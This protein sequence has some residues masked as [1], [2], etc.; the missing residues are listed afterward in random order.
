MMLADPASRFSSEL[1]VTRER[2]L[3][4]TAGF[5]GDRLLGPKLA[6]VNPPLW[7]IGHVGWFQERW[8]LRW[9]PDGGLDDSL[10]QNADALY[11]SSAVAHD[12]R[13]NLPLPRLAATLKYLANVLERVRERLHREPANESLHYFLWLVTYHEQ[14]HTEAFHYTCQTLGYEN[15]LHDLPFPQGTPRDLEMSGGEFPLGSIPGQ[16]DF[17]FDNEK[18]AHEV[19][20][21]P[22]NIAKAPVTNAE[23]LGYVEDGGRPPRY[24]KK[25]GSEWI[26]RRF[27]QWKPLDPM[28][29]VRHVDW[30]EA[31]AWCR[32]AKRRLPTEA[33]WEYAASQLGFKWR[34]LWEWTSSTFNPYPGFVID[35]Y[36]EYSAPWFGTHKV[37]RGASF[38][39]ARSRPKFRNFYT[40]DR[41]DV[42][43][44]FRTCSL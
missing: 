20:I 32:W 26:E 35:P 10:L 2:T 28:E 29:F 31:Q 7:E 23:Y 4:A 15:P 25:V 42:F 21:A 9:R 14:M 17:V 27:D 40:A 39:T 30:N 33:E 8:C 6:I 22:F 1:L 12:T 13:W 44:G 37:L 43:C 34:S 38:A 5:R 11:D 3:R 18:W 36:K 16:E 24:W 19:E 41:A